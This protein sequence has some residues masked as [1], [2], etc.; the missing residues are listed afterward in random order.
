MIFLGDIACPYERVS[1]FTDAVSKIEAFK[2]EIVVLNLEANILEKWEEKKPLTLYNSPDVLK[3]FGKSRKVVVSLANNHMF[4]YP[5]KILQTVEKME[6]G[7][8]I[9]VWIE[10]AGRQNKAMRNRRQWGEDG[11]LR[12]LLET[13]Y[14]YQQKRRKRSK[15]I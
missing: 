11:I 14:P 9:M 10:R 4:D 2:D 13:I 8:G 1:A 12:S 7:G 15:H 3:G 6:L 5:D